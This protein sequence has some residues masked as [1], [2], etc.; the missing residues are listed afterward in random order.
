MYQ[1]SLAVAIICLENK[2]HFDITMSFSYR[3]LE[4]HPTIN[5]DLPHRIM[6]GSV[7]VRPHV[8]KFGTKHVEFEDGTD[9][10]IDAVIFA[11]GKIKLQRPI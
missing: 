11:T 7:Q 8:T 10:E 9:E 4:A 6:V 3:A 2:L 5:D 1:D